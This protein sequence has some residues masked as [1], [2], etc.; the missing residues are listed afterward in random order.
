MTVKYKALTANDFLKP[1]RGNRAIKFVKMIEDGEPFLLMTGKEVV[2]TDRPAANLFAAAIKERDN[3]TVNKMEFTGKDRRKYKIKEFAKTGDFGGMGKGSGTAREDEALTSIRDQIL[4][5]CAAEEERQIPIKIGNRIG[6][7][8]DAKTTFGT[9]KSDFEL[10]DE[11]G[12]TSFWISHKAGTRAKDFQQYGGLK[13][14]DPLG[15]RYRELQAF[16][17][18]VHDRVIGGKLSEGE[19]YFRLLKDRTMILYSLFGKDYRSG[20]ATGVNNID[21]LFQGDLNLVK[22][23]RH[24]IIKSSHTTL[25]GEIPIG[26]YAPVLFVRRDQRRT[27]YGIGESRFMISPHGGVGGTAQEI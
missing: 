20:P 21:V 14:L 25:R 12:K 18:A 24:Y 22:Q 8:C 17:K 1:G 13:E 5:A 6:Y 7:V 11:H 15:N 16:I 4:K 9:P 27:Q 3:R 23:G 26:D 19:K 10:V 2:L